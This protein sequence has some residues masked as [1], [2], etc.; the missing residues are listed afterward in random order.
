M[1]APKTYL[2]FIGFGEMA[3]RDEFE[4]KQ[5]ALDAVNDLGEKTSF[6]IYEASIATYRCILNTVDCSE[7][8]AP[9]L[10]IVE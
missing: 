1:E 7:H 8:E 5:D 3:Y 10:R 6:V 2:L 4:T 9:Y